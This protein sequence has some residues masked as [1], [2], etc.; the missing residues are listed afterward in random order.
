L[1]GEGLALLDPHGDLAL[2]ALSHVPKHR[3]NYLAYIDPADR[4]WPIG[5]NPL[6][7]VRP[8]LRP[9]TAD[10]V[11]AAFRHVWPD[12]WGPRLDYILA[13]AVRALL[14]VPGATLLMLPRLLI[15]DGFRQP[16][17]DRHAIDPV[18]RAFWMN[19]YVGYA[20]SDPPAEERDSRP[21]A[22]RYFYAVCRRPAGT[23]AGQSGYVMRRS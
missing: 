6:A 21:S 19:E 14:D 7:D 13:N 8:E 3:S 12:S 4:D 23:D 2:A 18:V 17:I 5:F 16:L 1:A 22:R 20:P 9:V 10:G 15:D 11:V